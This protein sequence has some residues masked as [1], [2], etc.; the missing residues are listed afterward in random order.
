MYVTTSPTSARSTASAQLG[1]R[2][3][4]PMLNSS[5]K[6]ST[7]ALNPRS[8][9]SS[10]IPPSPSA[11]T[12]RS[13]LQGRVVC[14]GGQ[15]YPL[16]STALQQV[17]PPN[18]PTDTPSS[19]YS[20]NEQSEQPSAEVEQ[21]AYALAG[22]GPAETPEQPKAREQQQKQHQQQINDHSV[23]ESCSVSIDMLPVELTDVDYRN[24]V[25]A[26]NDAFKPGDELWINGRP[27]CML[28]WNSETGLITVVHACGQAFAV[29]PWLIE[30]VE[31]PRISRPCSNVATAA[32][33][34][35]SR[36]SAA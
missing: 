13:A 33:S 9:A 12:L 10:S 27:F 25:A 31:R 16:K 11:R 17:S 35:I 19:K 22:S 20:L 23:D 3:I 34:I 28:T 2:S 1:S 15:T 14:P 36:I 7:S 32:Q 30:R 26:P 21:Q 29:Q 24:A 4:G 8:T 5:P 6:P 18:T